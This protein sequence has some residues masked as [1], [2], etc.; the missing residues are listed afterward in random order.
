M[1]YPAAHTYMAHIWEYSPP[2]AQESHT[3]TRNVFVLI[4]E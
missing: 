4:K 2:G 1:P 3:T